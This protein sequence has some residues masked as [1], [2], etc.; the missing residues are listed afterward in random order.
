M[1]YVFIQL[2]QQ[3]KFLHCKE[4]EEEV[5]AQSRSKC[6]IFYCPKYLTDK[7]HCYKCVSLFYNYMLSIE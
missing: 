7:G 6:L 2:G 1:S 3:D 5:D 4:E